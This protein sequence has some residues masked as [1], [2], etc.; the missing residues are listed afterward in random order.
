MTKMIA[1]VGQR[2]RLAR[3]GWGLTQA[4]LAE[5]LRVTR[6]AISAWE[7]GLRRL[8]GPAVVALQVIRGLNTHW[9][10]TGE[11]SASVDPTLQTS[12]SLI[13]L[14]LIIGLA[15]WN[16]GG[17]ITLDHNHRAP[18]PLSEHAVRQILKE[19]GGGALE[20][21]VL[22][23]DLPGVAPGL[24]GGA[25]HLLNVFE[26]VRES[27]V[28]EGIYLFRQSHPL[29][30]RFVSLAEHPQGWL[31]RPLGEALEAPMVVAKANRLSQ[32]ILGRICL[33]GWSW[34]G[35]LT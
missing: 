2:L 18:W 28:P 14:P 15:A 33:T 26:E 22:V 23:S 6:S 21:L 30:G 20:H 32:S 4:Q 24:P 12:V 8:E 5:E 31:A 25:M 10:M 1:D 11:G 29:R 35:R 16:T 17:V 9:L 7:S 3:E 27:P 13:R 34:L 19:S